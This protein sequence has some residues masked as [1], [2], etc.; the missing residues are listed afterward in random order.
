M[1]RMM[2]APTGIPGCLVA[3]P[4]LRM[5]RGE[6][7]LNERNTSRG[8]VRH[9]DGWGAVIVRD[10][11]PRRVRSP[12]ACWDDAAFSEI[13][14]A[15]VKLLHARLASSAGRGVDNAH[16]FLA[17]VGGEAWYFCHNGTLTDEPDDGTGATDSE[18]FFRRMAPLLDQ[19][20]PIDAFEA[21]AGALSDIT[22]L[23]ALLLSPR[24]LWAFCVWADSTYATYY[25]LAFAK[26]AHGVVVASEPLGDIAPRWTPME[27]GTALW[28]PAGAAEA[29]VVRLRLP[30][31]ITRAAA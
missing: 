18:R 28:V 6:N 4:F 27:N 31:A 29:R 15:D 20:D 22:A 13:R 9:G 14:S 8:L 19:G 11:E 21:T 3:D 7:A 2:A 16:P 30:D 5:A 1:C 23:N 24:G 12:L 10:E 17:E 25:T 26:T